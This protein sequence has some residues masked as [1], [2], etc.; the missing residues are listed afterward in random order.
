M[1]TDKQPAGID[2]KTLI[3]DF[4]GRTGIRPENPARRSDR[5][6]WTDAYAVQACFGLA[7]TREDPRYR[8][9]ALTLIDAVHS[10]LGRHRPDDERQGWISGLSEAKGARHPTA[11]GLRIGK[12]RP[13]RR[14]DEPFD[15]S[16]EWDRDGQYF[17][18]LTR[19]IRALL[20]AYR[21]TGESHLREWAREL[22]RACDAFLVERNGR[23]HMFWKISIDRSRPQV[24]SM[25]MHD[26][27]DGLICMH[28]L[29]LSLKPDAPSSAD[30]FDQLV[31][32]CR[33]ASWATTD[34]LGVG[35]L[36]ADLR[37]LLRCVDSNVPIPKP[38]DLERMLVEVMLSL[39]M[40]NRQWDALEPAAN[41]LAFRE[42]GL[43]LGIRMMNDEVRE[44]HVGARAFRNIQSAST[45]A[46][47]VDAFWSEPQHREVRTWKDHED[48]NS[49][50]L[51]SSLIARDAPQAFCLY[52]PGPEDTYDAN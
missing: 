39:D 8:D 28:A 2:A 10:T 27:L 36:L 5:Y 47:E 32:L 38:L 44:A 31:E 33:D 41:R 7:H 13:E 50:M 49:V 22:F 45:L 11:G 52:P 37:Y 17:H 42:A 21:E 1:T 35:G 18:Y 23:P 40:H 4:L 34:S 43:S 25:G 26:P 29:G 9:D 46:D 6:L 24:G 12:A 16:A 48:I 20:T 19:W 14:P 30:A 15:N 3:D 51:A